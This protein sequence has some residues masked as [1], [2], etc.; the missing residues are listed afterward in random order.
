MSLPRDCSGRRFTQAGGTTRG[1]EGSSSILVILNVKNSCLNTGT[2][3]SF[4]RNGFCGS[5]TGAGVV[6]TKGDVDPGC[7]GNLL[8]TVSNLSISIGIVSG[9]NA[10]ARPTVTFEV[11][12]R[13]L[14]SGCN[15]RRTQ[16]EVCTAASG[17]GNTLGRLTSTRNCRAFII[18]SS[19]NKEFSIL[20]TMKLLP[21]T[22]SNTS[23]STVV[24]NT[25]STHIL[26][27]RSG[28]R[29]GRYCRCT[30][31]EGVLLERNGT[32]RVLI[33]CSPRLACFAR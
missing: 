30:T 32:I 26:C 18:P 4:L 17:G 24:R 33:G 23:V 3:V 29:A 12:E 7:L 1:V 8:G 15:R 13:C 6:F 21:V 5:A 9:S 10:A 19:I 28:L 31:M 20:A 27:T 16:G 25:G 11:F 14:T 2:T 22:I